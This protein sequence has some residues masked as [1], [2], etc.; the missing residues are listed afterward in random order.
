MSCAARWL[1]CMLA[2]ALAACSAAPRG[3]GSAA[4]TPPGGGGYYKDDGPGDVIPPNL[5]E[6]PDAVPKDEP[7]IPYANRP[8]EVFGQR[9]VPL[10]RLQPYHEQ[11]L[12]SW[13]GRRYHRKKTSSGELYDMYA[14]TAAHPT[15]PIPS[16]ARVTH[17][18]SGR[19]VVVRINDR[20]PFLGGR[21]I[22][23]SYVAAYKLGYIGSGSASVDVEAIV[24]GEPLRVVPATPQVAADAAPP[25]AASAAPLPTVEAPAGLYLQLAAFSAQASAESMRERLAREL[26]WLATRIYVVAS[27]NLYKVQVGPYR[28]RDDAVDHAERIAQALNFKP[29]VVV[30]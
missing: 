3:D 22:D 6:V 10:R 1:V 20:G 28:S 4:S 14:M 18:A 16:Y 27:G 12:A 11:G 7:L 13:Y 30:R 21:V 23:L 5:A 24:P 25:P 9:Y 2:L 19:S 15:L 26:D 29:F 8:Y 17:L